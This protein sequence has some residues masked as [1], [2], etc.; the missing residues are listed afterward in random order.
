V[1]KGFRIFLGVL[2]GVIII[3]LAGLYLSQR[4]IVVLNPKG[5]IGMKQRDLFWVST[6]LMLIVVIPVFV[7]TIWAVWKYRA[8][9]DKQKYDPEWNHST[10]AEIVWWGIPF[11]IIII[12]SVL[13]WIACYELDP[14]KPIASNKKTLTIQVVALEWK[15]LFIYP[16]QKIATVNFIQIPVDTPVQFVITADAPMNSFWIPQLGG[17]IFA[18]PAMRTELYLIANEKGDYRGVSANLSGKGFSGMTFTVRAGSDEEFDGW[19]KEVQ[20]STEA[21]NLESYKILAKP[22]ENNP[23]AFYKLEYETLFDWILMKDMMPQG[24]RTHA[25]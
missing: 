10:V 4:D 13:N 2:L 9:H 17:Q 19:I 11:I 21:L 20:N 14:F 6:A 16:D 25:N 3:V 1:K 23:F 8:G 5:W 15:W 22:S 12:L 7:L 24:E 18:M